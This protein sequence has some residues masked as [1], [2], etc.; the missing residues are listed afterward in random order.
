MDY[1]DETAEQIRYK[2]QYPQAKLSTCLETS[3][4][5]EIDPSGPYPH[6]EAVE[7]VLANIKYLKALTDDIITYTDRNEM[8]DDVDTFTKHTVYY[9]KALY[10]LE[11][12]LVKAQAYQR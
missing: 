6:V 4:L 1:I 11:N 2:G 5:Q 12:S 10:F 8:W 3:M 9:A 7:V